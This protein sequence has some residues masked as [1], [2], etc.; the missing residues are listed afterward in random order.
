[1][2]QRMEAAVTKRESVTPIPPP[3]PS[4]YLQYQ[5]KKGRNGPL[6]NLFGCVLDWS[7]RTGWDTRRQSN[8]R[9]PLPW[10]TFSQTLFWSLPGVAYLS[11]RALMGLVHFINRTIYLKQRPLSGLL[12]VLFY[13]NCDCFLHCFPNFINISFLL[14]YW[15]YIGLQVGEWPLWEE[16]GGC[17]VSESFLLTPR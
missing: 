11:L 1:M 6:Q 10:L 4:L 14:L 15:A 5:S 7:P 16:N 3:P 9:G 8:Q 12:C 17:S 13:H 2:W